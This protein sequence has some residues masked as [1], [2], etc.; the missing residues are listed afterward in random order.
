M[1]ADD[2]LQKCSRQYSIVL[3]TASRAGRAGSR[4]LSTGRME[5]MEPPESTSGAA[6]PIATRADARIPAD[7]R[8]PSPTRPRVRSSERRA[9]S[10]PSRETPSPSDARG[11]TPASSTPSSRPSA[12]SPSRSRRRSSRSWSRR[13]PAS[14]SSAALA[15]LAAQDY[16]A[17][18]V[19]VLD[20][21]RRRRPD[22][23]DRGRAA[24]RVRAPAPREP[25]A[26]RPR[27]TRRCSTVEGATFLLFCHDDVV[28][29]PD[30]VRVMVEEAYRSNAG[31]VGP[32]LVDY[33]HPEV[34]L[35]V[36]MTVD[37]YGV[38]FS[39]IEPGEIDQEQHDGVRDVFFVSHAAMLVRADLF[40]ELGG[41]DVDTAPGSDDIDLCWRARLAGARVLVAPGE[42]RAA[43]AGDG[44]RASGARA[45]SR[46]ARR[47]PRRAAACACSIKSYSARRAVVGA[48]ERL[49]AHARRGDRARARPGAG[50]TPVAVVAGWIP[51]AAAW[52]DLRRARDGDAGDAPGRRRRHPRPDGPGQRAL[53]QPARAAAARRRP[54]GRRVEPGAGA[55]G[56][57]RASRCAARRRSS[58]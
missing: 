24:D 20:N 12:P 47:A 36:G 54:A 16:P 17:L 30:A 3:T 32:K 41:F 4:L 11:P 40:R 28:L 53:P 10:A 25:S 6:G 51:A 13:A 1:L 22:R 52:R 46:R 15:S 39:A 9:P 49:R 7:V 23:P 34:L 43:P 27:P 44:D 55:H 21:A 58:R 2:G 18:S 45:G 48:A 38:P 26:S 8:A 37:H 19:L 29:D 33:D 31:I 35:E 5:T 42:P 14:G 57:A 50:A 56:A